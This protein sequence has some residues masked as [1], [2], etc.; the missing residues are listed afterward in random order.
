MIHAI[1]QIGLELLSQSGKEDWELLT[2]NPND[3]GNYPAMLMVEL[4]T[5]PSHPGKWKFHGVNAEETRHDDSSSLY[6]YRRRGANGANYSPTCLITKL[7]KTWKTRVLSW[8][9]Y[10]ELVKKDL[11]EDV[12][13]LIRSVNEVLTAETE[14]ILLACRRHQETAMHGFGISLK[15]DGRYLG[16]IP[17]FRQAFVRLV[18]EKDFEVYAS[19][20]H[21][22]ICGAIGVN[23]VGNMS[24][25]KFYTLDK[26]GFVSGKF[27]TDQ[28]WRNYPVCVKC[29]S[30][31]EEGKSYLQKQLSFS[32]YGLPYMIVPK[33][34]FPSDE[35]DFVLKSIARWKHKQS[36][37]DSELKKQ[38]TQDEQEI[39]EILTEESNQIQFDLLFLRVEQSGAVE[40]VLLHLEDIRS[41]RLKQLFDAKERVEKLF[42]LQ[43]GNTYHFG[44]LR[45]FFSKSDSDKKN[46]DLDKYFLS[47]VDHVFTGKQLDPAFLYPHFMREIRS[48]LHNEEQPVYF[49]IRDAVYN[50]HFFEQTGIL[51]RKENPRMIED[52]YT[53]LIQKYGT[54]LDQPVKEGLFLLGGL[55]QMLLDIQKEKRSATP[56]DKHLK[57]LRMNRKDVMGLM[58]RVVEKLRAYDE[59]GPRMEEL[60]AAISKRFLDPAGDWKMSID[61]LNFYI[62]AGMAMK[63]EMNSIRYRKEVVQA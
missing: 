53:E 55:T 34:L 38:L 19:N 62:A 54:Q 27:R 8:F 59:Y 49:T 9:P 22:S 43:S 47:I 13:Q 56:F 1:R 7:E 63:N 60:V 50:L 57:G 40:R 10:A 61:E 32:F 18:N 30:E 15:L 14:S 3:G 39:F 37:A 11:P 4:V 24:V 58:N 16:E 42:S 29:K 48:R 20:K 46:F 5:D 2:Q 44:K 31:I 25:F 36:I 51:P 17:E 23:V 12:L 41:I 33:W 6:L 45:T 26:P 52:A 21:C 28:A 35:S